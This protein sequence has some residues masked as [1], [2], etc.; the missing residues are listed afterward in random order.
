[1]KHHVA[2]VLLVVVVGCTGSSHSEGSGNRTTC[3]PKLVEL[4]RFYEAVAADNAAPG[5]TERVGL[6]V[7]DHLAAI[8]SG[9]P[10]D[11]S[12]ANLLVVRATENRLVMGDD[13]SVV[14]LIEAD[15]PWSHLE[16]TLRDLRRDETAKISV[17]YK[18][19]GALEGRKRPNIPGTDLD[20]LDLP[21]VGDMIAQTATAHCPAYAK[22][23][24][25][26][27]SGTTPVTD[28][29]FLRGLAA[30]LPTCDC[31]VRIGLLE[32]MPWLV[33][34]SHVTTVPLAAS[35][36]THDAT[37]T[38][39]DLVAAAKGPV[40]LALPELPPPPPPPPPRHH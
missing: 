21:H 3:A 14:L 9:A 10:V 8:G 35:A 13:P 19:R 6:T 27:Q 16:E 11:V 32:L 29:G 7:V 25:A 23:L 40:P 15:V 30:T 18:V 28:P 38:W 37:Q 24:A 39:G 17:A 36:P 1:M 2:G 22:Q 26:L 34:T 31:E 5:V 20:H 4:S 12:H 33:A